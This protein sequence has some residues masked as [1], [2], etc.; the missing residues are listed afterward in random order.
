MTKRFDDRLRVTRIILKA[1]TKSSLNWTPLTK[2][3]LKWSTPWKAQSTLEWLVRE[4][5]IERP[6]RGVYKITEKGKRFLEVISQ[7]L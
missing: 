1:L 5:Y 6:E 7:D 4:G 2:L 3:I